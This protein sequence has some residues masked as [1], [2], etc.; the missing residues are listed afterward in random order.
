MKRV[1]Q[2]SGQLPTLRSALLAKARLKE[3]LTSDRDRVYSASVL[4]GGQPE[5][6]KPCQDLLYTFVELKQF[7]IEHITSK[8]GSNP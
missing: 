3:A 2:F 1:L 6:R 4:Q 5:R 7:Y 8:V